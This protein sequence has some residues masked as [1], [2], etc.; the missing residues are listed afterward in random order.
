[1]IQDLKNNEMILLELIKAKNEDVVEKILQDSFF[2][3][4]KWKPVGGTDNNYSTISN[5]QSDPV[6]ALCEKPIN[7]IDHVLLKQCMKQCKLAGDDPEGPT[8][9]KTMKE[10]L[11]K[12]LKIP[13]GDFSK[14]S[15][16]QIKHLAENVIIFADGTKIEPNIII[17]DR[18]E[19]QRPDDFEKTLLSLQRGNKRKIKFVQGKYNMGGTG[20]L[21]FCGEKGYQ[22]I[23]ARKSV[24]LVGGDSEWGFTLMREKPDVSEAYKTTWYEYFTDADDKIFRIKAKPLRILPKNKDLIDG[25]F[26][27]LFSYELPR[28]SVI[29]LGLWAEL[30]TK[31]YAPALPITLYD[32]RKD[33]D[34]TRTNDLNIRTLYGNAFRVN[35]NFKKYVYKKYSI[36]SKLRNFGTNKIDVTVFNHAS[37]IRTKRNKTRDFR[38]ESETILLTQNGQTHATISQTRFKTATN[39]SNVANYIMVHVDL[40]HIPVSKSKMFL[41]SRDRARESKDYKELVNRIFKDLSDDDQL[42]AINEEYKLLDDKSTIK[43]TTLEEEISKV[44]RKNPTIMELLES[45]ELQVEEKNKTAVKKEFI[46][47]YIPTFLKVRGTEQSI[48]HEKQIPYTG[49]AAYIHFKTDAD[50]DYLIRENDRGELIVDWNSELDGTYYGPFDGIITVKLNGTGNKGDIIGDLRVKLTRPNLEPLECTV[51]LYFDEP[52]KGKPRGPRKEQNSGISM[53][54]FKW[55][56][57][58]EWSIWDWNELTVATADSESIRINRNC[59]HLE[60]FKRHRPSIDGKKIT[61]K[62]GFHIY[63]EAL[64]LYF[65]IKDDE[66]YDHLF[67]KA[68][69]AVAKACLP[70][71]YD[72][73][74]ESIERITLVRNEFA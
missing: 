70:L 12:Y 38:T 2:K 67:L 59:R 17:A 50:D 45:G 72:F 48:T 57:R 74:E 9:P 14:L 44:I 51:G 52:K 40:T 13:E 31:L 49:E 43:D 6:N 63:L 27:K 46:P 61:A 73:S 34:F 33:I 60:D 69:S 35:K 55:V 20:V 25:C 24:E 62:Y 1:M 58:D 65:E 10:A 47:K 29:T 37:K 11:E 56:T 54:K 26:I 41:A 16:E 64:M 4:V 42:K 22:L 39:F 28:P 36:H 53:P 21:P 15:Q 71:T 30:N 18:G 23:L 7:S 68:M 5:Q 8:A 19:G 66:N 3:D 32:N